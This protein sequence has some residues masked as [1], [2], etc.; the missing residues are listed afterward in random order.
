MEQRREQ[1][2][3][4]STPPEIG[5]LRAAGSAVLIVV[6]GVGGLVYGANAAVTN[7]GGLDR[8]Q[9]VGIATALFFG[10]FCVLAWVLRRLQRG[11]VI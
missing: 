5:W 7:L 10:G 9:R 8:P 1:V 6:V 4:S 11:H 3:E 2:S